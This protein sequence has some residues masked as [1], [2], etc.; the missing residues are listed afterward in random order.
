M[1]PRSQQAVLLFPLH[2][3]APQYSPDANYME[4]VQTSQ[5]KGRVFHRLPSLQMLPQ[6]SSRMGPRPLK[7][8]TALSTNSGEPTTP[9]RV[10]NLLKHLAE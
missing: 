9:L 6:V 7:L 5:V 2:L 8:L 4:F 10:S 3:C 1:E